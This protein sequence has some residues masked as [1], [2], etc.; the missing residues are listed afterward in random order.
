[1]GVGALLATVIGEET[2]IFGLLDGP[3]PSETVIKAL[4]LA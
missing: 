1:M 2:G 4:A 3:P